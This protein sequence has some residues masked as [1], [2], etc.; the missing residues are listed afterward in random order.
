MKK[1]NLNHWPFLDVKIQK[2]DSK[3]IT[4]VYRKPSFTGQYIRWDSFG[5]SKRKKNL[6][7]TLVHRALCI[8]SKSLLQQELENIRVILRD[9]DY[10]ESIIDRGISNKFAQFQSLPKFGPIKCPVYFKLPWIDIIS[11]KFENKIKF[12]VKHSFRAVEPRVLFST[13]K[14]F[15]SIH[16]DAVPSIQQSMVE[17]EYVCRCDCRY[18]G[19]TSLRL[20]ERI[21]QH[22]TNFIRRKQQPTKI[23]PE[24]KCK[25]RSTATHQQCG[26]AIRLH[27]MQLKQ[28][29]CFIF[30]YWKLHI[31]KS[32]KQLFVTKKS[33]FIHF[34]FFSNSDVA[35][36]QW[37]RCTVSW[38]THDF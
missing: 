8:C 21:N 29:P 4:S 3:F 35:C 32:G 22:V 25:I 30:R 10:P 2:S 36:Q 31:S 24:Q 37:Q 28:D 27:L 13:R 11:L 1:K 7:S 15:P 16:K 5:L 23:L 34:E 19:R 12:S 6:I 26:S 14:I 38:R 18:V 33:S 20:D 17:Y 9:N